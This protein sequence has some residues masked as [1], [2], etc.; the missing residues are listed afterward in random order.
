LKSR[1]GGN[2]EDYAVGWTEQALYDLTEA[3]VAQAPAEPGVYGLAKNGGWVYVAS[4]N[5]IRQALANYLGGKMP[6]LSQQRP[7]RFTFELV[8]DRGRAARCSELVSQLRPTFL[9][10][11]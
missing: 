3:G 6:W 2:R 4:T 9:N 10:C 11:A 7:E 1:V 8:D 5:N